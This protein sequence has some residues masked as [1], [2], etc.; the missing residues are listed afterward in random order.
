MAG[1]L[2]GQRVVLTEADSFM[3]PAIRELF[4]TE[5]ANVFADTR[6]LKPASAAQD[7]IAD[8]GATD[9]LIANLMLRNQRHLVP[10]T[11]DS[12]WLAMFDAMVHPL[13]RLVRAVLPQMLARR[14]G[15]IVVIGSANALRGTSPRAAYG[16]ARGA[17]LA[18]VK[19]VGIEVAPHGV[20]VNAMAQNF[21][22]NPTSYT[23]EIQAS[24][25][26]KEKLK[27][28]PV[29]RAA[30]GWESA[31]MALFLASRDSDFLH[32]QIVPFTGGW[33]A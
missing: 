25:E 15:K 2:T 14:R 13:H 4:E 26:F 33:I 28:V 12:E 9:I 10:D 23:P 20:N 5:G 8:A 11:P 16:A 32:G 29:G 6:D 7:L 22:S 31:A 1:R 30:H 19:N 3:G 17:Q 18:Y 27:E 21:V 24:Q